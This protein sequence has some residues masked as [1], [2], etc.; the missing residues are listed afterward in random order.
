MA[1]AKEEK[2]FA[3]QKYRQE[4][5]GVDFGAKGEAYVALREEVPFSSLHSLV[6]DLDSY[7]IIFDCTKLGTVSNA[8][9]HFEI[10][11]LL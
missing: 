2:A 1:R 10:L 7:A 3:E 6:T 9:N 5:L 4:A 11:F 8:F